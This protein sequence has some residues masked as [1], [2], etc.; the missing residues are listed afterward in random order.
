M[1]RK[2][3]RNLLVWL[4]VSFISILLTCPAT[5]DDLYKIKTSKKVYGAGETI[6]VNFSG[7]PGYRNDWICIVPKGT[8]DTDAGDYDY[9]GSGIHKGSLSFSG[10]P[11]G[12][13]EA[14]AYFDYNRLGYVV[15]ARYAFKVAGQA[16]SSVQDV[17]Q[18]DLDSS[19]PAEARVPKGKALIYIYR[20]PLFVTKM[21]DA[22]VK[23]KGNPP[24]LLPAASYFTYTS[25]PGSLDITC[26]E[27]QEA[28][29]TGRG[30]KAPIRT[31][32]YAKTQME[33][34]SGKVYYVKL[35]VTPGLPFHIY[36]EQVTRQTGERAFIDYQMSPIKPQ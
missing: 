14:R 21:M 23:V 34:K 8:P 27:V 6:V 3:Y 36:L 15:T 10:K 35:Q 12:D 19:R 1:N 32:N 22:R 20:E 26:D 30:V 31:S 25:S 16:S 9:T 18:R 5:A 17:Y 11:S 13:Y 33:V 24:T 4:F 28:E 2:L 29:W 7:A